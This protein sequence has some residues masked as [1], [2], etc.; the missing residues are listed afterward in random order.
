MRLITLTVG[1][2]LHDHQVATGRTHGRVL[3][4]AGEQYRVEV[5]ENQMLLMERD[6]LELSRSLETP[7]D[8]A[9]SAR[10]TLSRIKVAWKS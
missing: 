2:K 9:M 10:L 8:L 6:C 3:Q 1:R 5:T 4:E 7:R